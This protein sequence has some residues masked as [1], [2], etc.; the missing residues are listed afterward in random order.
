MDITSLFQDFNPKESL[1]NLFIETL[2]VLLIFWLLRLVA[3]KILQRYFKGNPIKRYKWEKIVIY[4]L[5]FIALLWSVSI[6]IGQFESLATFLGLLSAG[7]AIA[8]R[9]PV[10]NFA[11]WVFILTRQP[12]K[13][14]D[15]IEID[16]HKG[17]V[18]DI[19]IFQFTIIEV[20][21]W[22]HADQS[23]G[24]IIH[25]PNARILSLPI[26]NYNVGF[27]YIWH[28]IPILLTFE[29]DWKKA[30][31]IMD[32]IVRKHTAVFSDD[33]KREMEEA[34]EKKFPVVYHITTP[35][36]YTSVEDSGVLLTM[37]FLCMPKKRRSTEESIWEETLTR[38]AQHDNID[39]AYPTMRVTRK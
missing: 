34:A 21:N 17:D 20:G 2:V 19:R 29:S 13:L 35:I 39:F 37:R 3:L 31:K 9:E 6:W 18:I 4:S 8:L 1:L 10:M 36:V 14:G 7:V 12:F 32:E 24:R 38:F 33:A 28:E 15:R 25:L 30:K 11:G 5:S 22:V 16:G 26:A 23:T 27:N